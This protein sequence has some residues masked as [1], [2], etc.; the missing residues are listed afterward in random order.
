VSDWKEDKRWSDRFL[1]QIKRILGEYLIGE[2]SQEEDAL[3]NTDLIVLRMEA[4][5]IACRLRKS[6]K[7]LERYVGD[8][9]IR[10]NRPSG[11]KTELSKIIEGFGH[12]FFYG[13]ADTES[14][15]LTAW[16]LAD[17]SVFRLWFN[18]ELV[19]LKGTVPGLAKQNID[20]SSSFL[21]FKWKDLPSEFVVG[22]CK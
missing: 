22:S 19:R 1:P 16:T 15:L 5:R 2:A 6:D 20:G 10:S 12:Y 13:F 9:T 18:L 8:F 11:N 4:V 7:Y 14:G 3:R 17:L 21:V